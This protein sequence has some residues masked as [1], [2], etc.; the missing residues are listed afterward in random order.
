MN[1]LKTPIRI[2]S[3]VVCILGILAVSGCKQ[4]EATAVPQKT[5]EQSAQAIQNNPNMPQYAKDMA[6]RSMQEAQSKYQAEDARMK[7]MAAARER[8]G[9]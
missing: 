8:A 4:K 7:Q 6:L 2:V 9:K 3:A 5:T 1:T